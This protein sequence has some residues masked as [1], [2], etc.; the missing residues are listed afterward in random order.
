M[1]HA[2]LL[3]FIGVERAHHQP[4]TTVV[5]LRARAGRSEGHVVAEVAQNG[6][7]G[8]LL[9]IVPNAQ[10]HFAA[11][12]GQADHHRQIGRIVHR[13]AVHAENDVARLETG[14]GCRA[15]FLD[16]RDQRA[17]RRLQ[18][19]RGRQVLRHRLH[20]DA[21]PC[22][23]HLAM[24]DD[25]LGHA[26]GH[27]DRDGE[28]QPFKR[29]GLREDLRVDADHFTLGVE[30][31]PARVAGV[32]RHVGLN[33][34]HHAVVGQRAALGTHNARGHRVVEAV[35]RTDGQHPVTR[36]QIGRVAQPHRGQ[37]GRR[38]LDHRDVGLGVVAQHLG[39]VSA[40]VGE[41][42]THRAG[43]LDDVRVGQ[44][45]PVGADDEARAQAFGR[46][47]LLLAVIELLEEAEKRIVLEL[48]GNLL[49][50][51][52][53]LGFALHIDVHHRRAVGLDDGS[54]VRRVHRH[55]GRWCGR[56]IVE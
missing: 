3:L 20:R 28:R 21:Q 38:N 55:I 10:G 45:Q 13:L 12:L 8:L 54:E 49:L 56:R 31:R 42:H 17:A 33:E 11:G 46:H 15:V 27:I 36:L 37:I 19:K 40:M 7:D 34:G 16:L 24:L 29:A 47:F 41:G 4:Q 9:V 30:Q 44:N 5:A 32:H 43:A 48:L 25:L 52:R 35:G 14:L 26:L 2:G 18:A 50:L 39:L 6:G 53:F 51:H 23:L 22:V 1:R